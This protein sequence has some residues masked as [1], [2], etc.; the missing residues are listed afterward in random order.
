MSSPTA[1]LPFR[2]ASVSTA[3]SAA[4]EPLVGVQRAHVERY[5]RSLGE[6]G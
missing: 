5:I 6:R 4:V 1:L 3:Q 2:P